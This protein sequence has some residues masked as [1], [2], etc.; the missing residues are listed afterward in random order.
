TPEYKQLRENLL[1]AQSEWER[2]G[3]KESGDLSATI[4]VH[5]RG[6]QT[7][8]GHVERLEESEV[9]SVPPALS[10]KMGGP[11]AVKQQPGPHGQLIPPTQDYYVWSDIHG[12]DGA[13]EPG[14][15]GQGKVPLRPRTGLHWRWSARQ[16]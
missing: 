14:G 10:S 11:I 2:S 7:W 5:G 4:R 9:R 8:Q 16:A 6:G 1:R 3:G 13:K 15:G 12:P